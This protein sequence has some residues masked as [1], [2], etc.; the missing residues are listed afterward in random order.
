MVELLR[1]AHN[2]QQ[3]PPASAIVVGSAAEETNYKEIQRSQADELV[4]K[5]REG[6]QRNLEREAEQI[7]TALEQKSLFE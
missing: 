1:T 7:K 2:I 4:R 5:D 3:L 6:V